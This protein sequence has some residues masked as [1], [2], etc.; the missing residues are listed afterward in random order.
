M[1]Q[2]DQDAIKRIIRKNKKTYFLFFGLYVIMGILA[3]YRFI[4]EVLTD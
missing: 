2:E 3:V 1:D 4:T